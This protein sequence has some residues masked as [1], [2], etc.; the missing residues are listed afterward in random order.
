MRKA[1]VIF[2]S[3]ML[4][5]IGFLSFIWF[6]VYDKMSK[7]KSELK[8]WIGKKTVVGKDTLIITDVNFFTNDFE[9]SN[10]TKVDCD[11]V[12]KKKN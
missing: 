4:V 5:F 1:A 7:E 12:T 8:S 3:F 2:V 11:F 6:T 9:L 10:G